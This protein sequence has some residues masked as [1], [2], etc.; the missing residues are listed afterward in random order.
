MSVNEASMTLAI[1]LGKL[2]GFVVTS[3]Y[4]G[5]FGLVPRQK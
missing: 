5:I 4:N 3:T 1:N 2:Q